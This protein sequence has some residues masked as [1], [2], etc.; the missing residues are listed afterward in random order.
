M[1]PLHK[2]RDYIPYAPIYPEQI[3]R[4]VRHRVLLGAMIVV[5]ALIAGSVVAYSSQSA[6]SPYPSPSCAALK[7]TRNSLASSNLIK[8]YVCG[9]SEVSDGNLK[10]TLNDYLFSVGSAID[11]VCPGGYNANHSSPSCSSSGV[12]LLAN[13]TITNIGGGNASIG[14]DLQVNATDGYRPASNSEYGANAVFPGQYPNSSIPAQGG[15]VFLPPGSSRTYW[16][17]FYMPQVPASDI[18]NL[19]LNLISV[20]DQ[21]YGGDWEGGGSFRCIPKSCQDPATE[22]TVTTS[23]ATP[24]ITHVTT[25]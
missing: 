8:T 10:M 20:N 5:V 21:L 4:A 19:K 6:L 17:I 13:I 23:P 1:G 25:R 3:F 14:P 15:G 7:I 11:W 22:L 12:Y 18:P 2:L 16:Y 24:N 9:S